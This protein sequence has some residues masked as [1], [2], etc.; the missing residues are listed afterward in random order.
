MR[1][2]LLMRVKIRKEDGVIGLRLPL[3]LVLLLVMVVMI[4]LSQ[5]ILVGV[6]VI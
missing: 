2:P 5:L 3:F 6:L 1:P 4:I